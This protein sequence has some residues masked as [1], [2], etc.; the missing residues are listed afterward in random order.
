M[1]VT[2]RSRY[3]LKIMMD[4][5]HF[6][7][8]PQVSRQDIAAR[9]EVPLDYLDQI[10]M[11]LRKGNLVESVR[12]RSGG[13]RLARPASE[14]SVWDIFCCVDGSLYPVRCL[15]KG[16]SCNL[17]DSCVTKDVWF[18]IFEAIRNPLS[19]L[20]LQKISD[21]QVLRQPAKDLELWNSLRKA[22]ITTL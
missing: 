5:A 3:A 4:L 8:L 22:A 16:E 20:T 17:Q 2:S 6:A 15:D 10:M 11:R 9:Q 7:D 19:E 12:G 18:D 13:Y 21:R 1:N 14:I